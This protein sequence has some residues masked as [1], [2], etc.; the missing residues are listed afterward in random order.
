M[1]KCNAQTN[2]HCFLHSS[3][4]AHTIWRKHLNFL[5]HVQGIKLSSLFLQCPQSS[6]RQKTR[7]VIIMQQ[8]V[9]GWYTRENI[10]FIP[11]TSPPSWTILTP[12]FVRKSET[13]GIS[14]SFKFRMKWKLL[15]RKPHP[16]HLNLQKNLKYSFPYKMKAWTQIMAKLEPR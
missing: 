13:W 8:R 2:D 6:H 4:K 7:K 5:E 12:N 9:K 11:I 15:F 16:S 14:L 1:R 10:W 3:C